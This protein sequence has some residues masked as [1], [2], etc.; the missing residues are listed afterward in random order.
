MLRRVVRVLR[1]SIAV[2]GLLLLAWM[3]LSFFVRTGFSSPWPFS[4]GGLIGEGTLSLTIIEPGRAELDVE[5]YE[6]S[7]YPYSWRH[8]LLPSGRRVTVPPMLVTFIQFPL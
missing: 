5:F 8:Y 1:Y 7:D 3:P 2:A 4:F 6:P